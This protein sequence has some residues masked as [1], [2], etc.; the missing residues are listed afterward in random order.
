MPPLLWSTDIM[1]HYESI[2]HWQKVVQFGDS[3]MG[4]IPKPGPNS[5]G[6]EFFGYIARARIVFT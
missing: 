1:K 6:M 2:S 4:I 5:A 3:G